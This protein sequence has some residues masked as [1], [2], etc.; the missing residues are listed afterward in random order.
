MT[1]ALTYLVHILIV[2]SAC[3]AALTMW[4]R[5]FD[6]ALQ[7]VSKDPKFVKGYYRLANAQTELQQFD[8]AET[9]LKAALTL[10][11]GS[12]A[13]Q[14]QIKA[15]RQRKAAAIAAAKAKKAPKK[16]DEAQMKE[17][18]WDSQL[19]LFCLHSIYVYVI[20]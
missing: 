3:F 15:V 7:S 10:D 2:Y 5:A 12:E 4:Q 1:S 16:M 8:D 14:R 20:W 9:T 18:N 17:V 11:P 13:V 6:D 19:D